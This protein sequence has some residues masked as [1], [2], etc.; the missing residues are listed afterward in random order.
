[1]ITTVARF[2]R[3]LFTLT[4]LVGALAAATMPAA[5]ATHAAALQ[6]AHLASPCPPAC[7]P[8]LRVLPPWQQPPP[9]C[10][11]CPPPWVK[12]FGDYFSL[13][14]RV[15]IIIILP[16]GQVVGQV[17]VYA[18]TRD[19]LGLGAFLVGVPV[20]ACHS[21]N[22]LAFARDLRTGART[23]PIPVPACTG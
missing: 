10:L 1:M 12:F 17:T 19:Q 6:R 11:N 18:S 8:Y 21:A 9:G 14:D 4:L 5:P 22:M 7:A 13:G 15:I 20:P 3:T 2:T 16:T 23:A